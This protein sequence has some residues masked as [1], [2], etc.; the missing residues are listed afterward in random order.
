MFV[1]QQETCL[2]LGGQVDGK[3]RVGYSLRGNSGPDAIF[4]NL[5]NSNN[6]IKAVIALSKVCR[7]MQETFNLRALHV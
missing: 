3:R 5:Q 1:P 2:D 7:S 6:G 4:P